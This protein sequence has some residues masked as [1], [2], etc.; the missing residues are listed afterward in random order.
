[1]PARRAGT[2]PSRLFRRAGHRSVAA[3]LVAAALLTGSLSVPVLAA[4]PIPSV[5]LGV[6]S[7]AMIGSTVS[8][9]VSFD[10]TSATDTGYGPYVD[11]RLP[12]GADL[13][14]GLTFS[15]ATYLGT[16]VTATQLVA[17]ASG[18]ITHPYA[19]TT[20]GAALQVCGL[21]VGQA[22]VVLR[23]PFGSVTPSQP[24]DADRRHDGAQQLR[25]RGH[26]ALGHGLGRVPVRQDAGR[27]S[28]HGPVDRRRHR[29]CAG[30]AHGAHAEQGVRRPRERDRDRAQLRA[31]VRDHGRY[32]SR[33]AGHG[34]RSQ[35]RAARQPPVPHA[36]RQ[37]TRV[38]RAGHTQHD[39]A[40]RRPHPALRRGDRR[41]GRIRRLVHVLVPRPAGLL[42]LDR[43]TRSGHRSHGAGH[44]YGERIGNL[45]PP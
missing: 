39:H 42:E 33:T 18:C 11:L 4:D 24:R 41:R 19:V 3:A 26:G 13:D 8:F 38:R 23:L 7:T 40:R 9:T 36:R 31:P 35:R 6:P 44:R 32:R 2:V 17:N 22:F 10:N 34:S 16:A 37:L 5:T 12:R 20:S 30:H 21:V 27:R 28:G 14:D 25:R 29:H 45:G 43:R 1:M 15:G